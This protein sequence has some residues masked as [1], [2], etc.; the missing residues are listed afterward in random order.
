MEK[1]PPPGARSA[2]AEL[3]AGSRGAP[4]AACPAEG[5]LGL[6][7]PFLGYLGVY[8]FMVYRSF[9]FLPYSGYL[10]RYHILYFYGRA[11]TFQ[12]LLLKTL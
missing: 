6:G 11:Y 10:L 3:R 1:G 4:A 9:Y 12:C 2:A 7:R 5:P 8:F